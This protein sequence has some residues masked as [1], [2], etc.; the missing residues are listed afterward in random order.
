MKKLL[1]FLMSIGLTVSPAATIISCGSDN[2]N[3]NT[4]GEQGGGETTDPN[5]EGLSYEKVRDQYLKEV[6]DFVNKNISTQV[7]NQDWTEATSYS[8]EDKEFFNANA[9]KKAAELAKKTKEE[10]SGEE[11]S[12]DLSELF[13]KTEATEL[14]TKFFA[15]VKSIIDF[16]KIQDGIKSIADK[17]EYSS[18]ITKGVEKDKLI[19]VDESTVNANNTENVKA[20]L[21]F[22]NKEESEANK[23]NFFAS[24]ENVNISFKFNFKAKDGNQLAPATNNIFNFTY[25]ITTYGNVVDFINKKAK[26]LKFKYLKDGDSIIESGLKSGSNADKFES[27]DQLNNK[28]TGKYITTFNS[29][30]FKTKLTDDL[31]TGEIEGV[32]F[33]I[34]PKNNNLVNE[35]SKDENSW[36]YEM[37]SLNS[38]KSVFSWKNEKSGWE[39]DK[40]EG[41][42]ELYKYIFRTASKENDTDG[43]ALLKKD[44]LNKA[45]LDNWFKDYKDKFVKENIEGKNDEYLTTNKEAILNQIN[46]TNKLKIVKLNSLELNINGGSGQGGFTTSIDDIFITAGYSIDKE[47]NLST[48]KFDENSLTYKSI[49][50]NSLKGINSYKNSFGIAPTSSEN[51]VASFSGKT[52]VNIGGKELNLWTD[53]FSS[54]YLSTDN[55]NPNLI[56]LVYE[57]G[58]KKFND[59]LSL[60][61]NSGTGSDTQKAVREKLLKEGNQTNFSWE[62]GTSYSD[63]VRVRFIKSLEDEG[64]PKDRDTKGFIIDG[65]YGSGSDNAPIR[66]NLD[67]MNI[68]FR[69]DTI[70]KLSSGNRYKSAIEIVE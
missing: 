54:D 47:E 3:G 7:Q 64:A 51:K 26:E 12:I 58:A 36:D 29:E 13:K 31:K 55:E 16:S 8:N 2:D 37:N 60:I 1:G 66:F 22:Y 59:N 43:E 57:D 63:R 17:K 30:E 56:Y 11:S 65:I 15:N 18:L 40:I 21:K 62:F 61:Q 34:K 70:W 5:Q 42:E 20:T 39:D 69:V 25:K 68:E 49:V 32:K 24:L 14:K 19:E 53:S 10:S 6:N 45:N 9:L 23:S 35:L 50:A 52:G 33:E 38:S 41:R 67:F 46:I 48:S 4:D 44:Y 27:Y 28:S